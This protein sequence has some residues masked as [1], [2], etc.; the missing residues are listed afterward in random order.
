M[1]TI[2]TPTSEQMA[3]RQLATAGALSGNGPGASSLS[4]DTSSSNAM[5]DSAARSLTDYL[6]NN[7]V[8]PNE[9][10]NEQGIMDRYG[11]ASSNTKSAYQDMYGSIANDYG[12]QLSE[13]NRTN[14]NDVNSTLESRSGFATNTAILRNLMD[15][16][17]YRVAQLEKA[18]DTALLHN[19]A[20]MANSLN[21][22]L[23]N[24]QS[25]L[26]QARQNY[27]ANLGTAAN[28]ETPQQKILNTQKQAQN[29]AVVQMQ[30]Q[31]P[32]AG[33]KSSDDFD[34]AV[35]KF[36]NST[37]YK[38]NIGQAEA[39]IA[40]A[41][42]AASAS[43]AQAGASSAQ[44]A[45]TRVLTGLI[46]NGGGNDAQILAAL[47]AGTLTLDNLPTVVNQSIDPQGIKRITSEWLAQG[48]NPVQNKADAAATQ[49]NASNLGGGGFGALSTG[50]TNVLGSF[51]NSA[52]GNNP[53]AP[54]RSLSST[55][56]TLTA[57]YKG[58]TTS[59]GGAT[60]KFDGSAWVKQK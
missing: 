18:R 12:G 6:Q 46:S 37:Y 42:A 2:P 47:K 22:L 54:N 33:I 58:Q 5:N 32:D 59:V 35:A 19:N 40:Q 57:P 14:Q 23:I 51:F 53:L 25:L 50:G 15:T 1:A 26:T 36:R 39:T 3:N 43:S 8:S 13:L 49:A 21:T 20:D 44:A 27:V 45:Q 30:A 52:F 34:S 10:T 38:N 24:E 11:T 29:A 56:S 55:P 48:G 41:Q 31:A 9:Q 28:L 4:P 60:Y 17:T 7:S 16:N